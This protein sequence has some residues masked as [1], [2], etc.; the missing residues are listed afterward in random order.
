VQTWFQKFK[1]EGDG[2]EGLSERAYPL[3]SGRMCQASRMFASEPV[4]CLFA[5]TALRANQK[6]RQESW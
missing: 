5:E 4:G 1:V 2:G 6:N 3:F